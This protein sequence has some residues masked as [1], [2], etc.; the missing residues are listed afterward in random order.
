[1]IIRMIIINHQF[2]IETW[3][4]EIKPIADTT[5]G[6]FNNLIACKGWTIY[7]TDISYI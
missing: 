1:M 7:N 5:R 3:E 6:V 2:S 4:I